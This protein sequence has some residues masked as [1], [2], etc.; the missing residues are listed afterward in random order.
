MSGQILKTSVAIVILALAFSFPAAAKNW[1][2]NEVIIYPGD[3]ITNEG[4]AI[5]WDKW[6]SYGTA[7]IYLSRY[8]HNYRQYENIE[9]GPSTNPKKLVSI[10]SSSTVIQKE[11]QN[12]SLLSYL[13]YDKGKI[14]VDEITPRFDG[15][16]DNDTLLYSMSIGKSLTSYILGHAI[17][18]GYID[19]LSQKVN[20][21]GLLK[22]TLYE[23]QSLLDLV[24]MNTGDYRHVNENEGMI[25]SGRWYNNH[26]IKS[27]AERELKGT[28]PSLKKYN[29]N[30]IPPNIVF[31]YVMHKTA[32]NFYPFI[33][34]IFREHIGIGRK[35]LQNKNSPIDAHG[36]IKAVF[37]A[38][39]YDFL[40]IAVA[41][42]K[43]WKEGSCVGK[44]LQDVHQFRISKKANMPGGKKWD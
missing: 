15:K 3:G 21:W 4:W 5:P 6:P 29:Y 35:L 14:I 18:D 34:K 43:D 23:N 44:Y 40:R 9:I 20:D 17:C 12:S 10:D 2:Q 7:K 36:S 13:L 27:L 22:N 42:L 19:G 41:M 30:G 31:G 33:D 11:M 28:R 32:D 25:A 38:S 37:F 8:L 39:R 26:S 24:N 16:I 1:N